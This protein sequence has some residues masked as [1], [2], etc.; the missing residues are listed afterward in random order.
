M[1][2]VSKLADI[3]LGLSADEVRK[4]VGQPKRTR[5]LGEDPDSRGVLAGVVGKVFEWEYPWGYLTFKRRRYG[6]AHCYRVVEKRPK[7]V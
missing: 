6:A 2:T 5:R 7:D 4:R 1:K 3:P